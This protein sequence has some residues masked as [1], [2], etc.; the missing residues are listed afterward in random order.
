KAS[1]YWYQKPIETQA[2]LINAFAEIANDKK[3][4]EAMKVWSLKSKQIKRW[5]TTKSTTEAVDAML[6]FGSDW[7]N[8]KDKTKFEL[9]DSKLFQKKIED[10][11]K[12]AETG[13]FKINFNSLEMKKEM[14]SLTIN[15]KSEV[16]G[17]GG[18][19]WQY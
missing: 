6:T 10:V 5:S 14:A 18:F 15:N 7:T 17:F 12:E 11:G 4:V 3:S 2:L 9:G 19:Y 16:P 8:V 1:W 13:Y